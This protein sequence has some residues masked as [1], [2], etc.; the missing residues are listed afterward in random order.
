M[1][2]RRCSGG[3]GSREVRVRRC[4]GGD[5]RGGGPERGTRASCHQISAR[6]PSS[7]GD[8]TLQRKTRYFESLINPI[9][10][11][12]LYGLTPSENVFWCVAEETYHCLNLH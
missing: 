7:P 5:G 10:T 8:I 1:R 6:S 2:V 9:E 4:S 11:L 12:V 3:D